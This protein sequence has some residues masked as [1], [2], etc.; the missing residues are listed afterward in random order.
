MEE[1]TKLW[2]KNYV[3]LL[4][5]SVLLYVGFMIF[6]PTLPAQ[7][8]ALGGTQVQAS[9]AVGLFSV[10]ALLTRALAGGWNDRFGSKILILI[11]FV[12]LILSTANFYLAGTVALLLALRLVQ[13]AGWGIGTTSI[14]TAVSLL[15]PPSRTGEGIG[16][17]GLTTALGL[18]FAPIIAILIM[19]YFSF[20]T[21]IT[22]SLVT[23]T[24]VF[25]LLTQLK[26]PRSKA[27]HTPHE[28]PK[29][30]ARSALLPAFLCFLMAIPLGGIQTFMMVYGQEELHISSSW[31]F[32]VGQGIMVLVSRLFAGRLYDEKGH[33]YVILP[34]FVAMVIGI[35]LLSFAGGAGMLFISSLFFGLG[36]GMTQP[37]LQ[38]L[39]I[40]RAAPHD[41]G[42]A[43]GTFLS[44][45]D[46]GMAV[47]SFG[48]SIIATF[49]SYAV[50]YRTSI[51]ALIIFIF[52][53]WFK[54]GRKRAV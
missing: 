2:T 47:G 48:L 3:F 43:N 38:A 53:Y 44:G 36:Y 29:M 1:N 46:I 18:S 13:G 35:I 39:A 40:D 52:I 7:I 20:N 5:G 49:F 17:Y 15:V 27:A 28:K 24:A 8:L 26:V 50:M 30:I 21:L 22:F 4:I 54:L 23:L 33:K 12:I 16:F 45:M 14:A 9:L 25:L 19:N 37:S 34:G 11:G 41:K 51:M 42:A 32:F 6:M 10:V 31:I